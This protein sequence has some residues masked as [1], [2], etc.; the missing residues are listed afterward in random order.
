M[1]PMTDAQIVLLLGSIG[2]ALLTA[3]NAFVLWRDRRDKTEHQRKLELL[4]MDREDK[5]RAHR[6]RMA[7]IAQMQTSQLS[8]MADMVHEAKA[9]AEQTKR[10]ISKKI[11]DSK[12]KREEHLTRIE[13]KLDD[14]TAKTVEGIEQA[15]NYSGKI[16]AIGAASLAAKSV[17]LQK[18]GNEKL[19]EIAQNTAPT[20]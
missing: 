2:N 8:E 4:V 20:P 16:A 17:E 14:N 19:E 11:D 10:D 13:A 1:E 3:W 7:E 6:H 5:E 9:V 18:E 15:N 12:E